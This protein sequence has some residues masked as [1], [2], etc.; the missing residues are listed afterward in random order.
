[1]SSVGIGG[2]Y[3]HVVHSSATYVCVF[4]HVTCLQQVAS[5]RSNS[6][7]SKGNGGAWGSESS[8]SSLC[9]H[10]GRPRFNPQARLEIRPGCV[11]EL[12]AKAGRTVP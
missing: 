12:Q 4:P 9:H 1:M 8:C 7:Q 2:Y 3:V 5:Y 10:P 6:D 11:Y